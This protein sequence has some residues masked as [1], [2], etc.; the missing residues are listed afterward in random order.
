[1]KIGVIGSNGQL[2]SDICIEFE[3]KGH[4]ILHLNHDRIEIGDIDSVASILRELKPDIIINTAAMHN[5]DNCEKNPVKSFVVNGLGAQNLSLVSREIDSV[6]IHISTDYVF[7]GKKRQPYIED[8]IPLPLNVY[9]NTK[10]SGEHFIRSIADK[11]FILRVSG[12]YGKNPCR[13]KGGMNFVK[14]MLK[15]TKDRDEIRVVDDEIL[16][17]TY[18]LDVAEQVV[19]LVKTDN[20]GLFHSTAQGSCSW[21]TFAAKIFEYTSSKVSLSV[22]NPNEFPSEVKRPKYSVLEN[23]VLQSLQ[24]DIMPQWEEGLKKY[25][26]AV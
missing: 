20:Y 3:K 15:L 11:Y 2:G 22:A 1:M 18:T 16:T 12:L 23:N 24:I 13:A 5:L 10:L 21:Y 17:P 19:E 4:A 6:L 8:D 14:L 7:D 9:G 26:D 25:L